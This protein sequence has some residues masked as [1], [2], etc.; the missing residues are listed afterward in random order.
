[1]GG[2]ESNTASG[3]ASTIAGGDSFGSQVLI[4]NNGNKSYLYV[5]T[6]RTE[7]GYEMP[8]KE[9]DRLSQEQQWWIRDWIDAGAPWPND[10]RVKLIQE[11]Y[12]EGEQVVT[13]KALSEDWQSR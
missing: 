7:D 1:M 6:T 8:P 4:P 3:A 9:A 11:V 10:D 5:T 12:A 2:G 13:S